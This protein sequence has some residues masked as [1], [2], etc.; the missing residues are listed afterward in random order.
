LS[1]SQEYADRRRPAIAEL[2][3][4]AIGLDYSLNDRVTSW[5]RDGTHKRM[6][7]HWL[8]LTAANDRLPEHLMQP[9]AAGESQGYVPPMADMLAV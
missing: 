2:A 7:N 6:V 8:G 5:R 3:I 1:E 9:L 4:R